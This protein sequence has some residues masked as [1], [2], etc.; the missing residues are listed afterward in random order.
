MK[1]EVSKKVSLVLA[2][3]LA[4]FLELV[5]IRWLPSNVLSISYFANIV[6]IASFLGL[7]I[8][9]LLPFKKD[10]FFWFP[11]AL[12]VMVLAVFLLRSAEVV[13]NGP[14]GEWLWSYYYSDNTSFEPAFHL[15]IIS[16]LTA[17]YLMVVGVFVFLG[18]KI[19]WC[20]GEFEALDSY[21]LTIAGSFL[22][23]LIF[24]IMT[25]IGGVFN[26]PALWFFIIFFISL[27]LLRKGSRLFLEIAFACALA[28]IVFVY[29]AD[30]GNLW[31]PYYSI[32]TYPNGNLSTKIYVNRFL[33]QEI[34]NFANF[35]F[36]QEKFLFPYYFKNHPENILIL[37]S[38]SGNDVAIANLTGAKSIDALEIDPA[39]AQLGKTANPQ[40]PY[41][42]P[43][44]HLFID[45]AR[46][47]LKKNDKHYDMVIL[48]TVDSHA[49]LSGMSN[50][51]L[52]SYLYTK[53]SLE[54]IKSHLNPNGV[55]V[56][57]F[58]AVNDNLADR[59]N[60][61]GH[62]AFSDVPSAAYRSADNRLFNFVF[63]AGP[64]LDPTL[65]HDEVGI[66]DL[67]VFKKMAQPSSI[68]S[69][70]IPSDDWPYLYL[71]SRQIPSH[72]V[73][74]ILILL[75]FSLLAIF[76][77]YRKRKILDWQNANFFFLGASFLLLETKS[78]TTLSLLF[79]ST[80]VVNVF[81]FATVL[82]LLY[83]AN[84][85][86]SKT[87][88]KNISLMYLL[89][90][91]LLAINFFLPTNLFLNF[92]FWPRSLLASLITLSPIFFSAVIFSSFFKKVQ[93]ESIA[94]RYGMNL[95]GAVVGGFLEYSS[96]IFGFKAL[97]LMAAVFYLLSLV[98]TLMA[99]KSRVHS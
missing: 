43:R 21:G 51:R 45:D 83:L 90:F 2:S 97:Y 78:I 87:E 72:Y 59:L 9:A 85:L 71:F 58:S 86:A 38:G 81:T 89:L 12:A 11:V 94:T 7:G 98:C 27:W 31:S 68:D 80:W 25:F 41:Q 50:V 96:M 4:L 17:L 47:F 61:V 10:L 32:Q 75:A 6:L 23:I 53:E 56:L 30:Q 77:L 49:L 46:S 70:V 76:A 88:I 19:A 65:I 48:G 36:G 24:G 99:L 5:F 93:Q 34:I 16:T 55:F 1:E 63:V 33:H 95:A 22:G 28:A 40:R 66:K 14:G 20:M 64:G 60:M 37:G 84:L 42:D 92:P 26:T 73:K 79:G 69:R 18:Q 62:A 57:L 13:F 54:D 52:E 15:G 67:L 39:I 82:L 44:V 29:L 3:F 91:G 8:G 74:A 35:K